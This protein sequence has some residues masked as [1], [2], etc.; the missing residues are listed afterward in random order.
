MTRSNETRVDRRDRGAGARRLAAAVCLAVG[1][2]AACSDE[3]ARPIPKGPNVIFVCMDTVRADH[4]GAYGYRLHATT[5]RIDRLAL[6]SIVFEDASATAP[7]TRPSVPSF[8]TGTYPLQHGIYGREGDSVAPLPPEALTIAEVY[9][10]AGWHTAAFV[11]N[12]QLSAGNGFEQGFDLYRERPTS[13]DAIRVAAEMWTE[14]LP[15]DGPF[16]LY[17]HFLDAHAPYPIPDSYA[18]LFADAATV[19]PYRGKEYWNRSALINSHTLKPTEADLD[20]LRALYDGG[21]RH[22]DDQLAVLFD[23]LAK[24]GKWDNTIVCILADH[25]EEFMEHGRIGHGHG[26]YEN[27][28]HVPWILRVPGEPARREPTPVSLVDVF[29]TLLSASGL[30]PSRAS[31]GIDRL[32]GPGTARA[33]FAENKDD[34]TYQQS[35]RDGGLKLIRRF[36]HVGPTDGEGTTPF[37]REEIPILLGQP[38][39]SALGLFDL[40]TDAG[41]L[42]PIFAKGRGHPLETELDRLSQDLGTRIR[43]RAG[44]RND[45]DAETL[46]RLKALGY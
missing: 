28:L 26:L 2:L 18:T 33:I 24:R 23:T 17:L 44:D 43:Y 42:A 34:E 31:E 21:I 29:P 39:R 1:A 11:Y 40:G 7:W 15:D 9:Q 13:A 6:E 14:Q 36:R 27:L 5:P 30:V 19:A 35:L 37:K 22:I 38:K 25:G 45:L 16:F 10:E 12:P 41:E 4:L 32:R 20:A 8:L 46:D 3:P